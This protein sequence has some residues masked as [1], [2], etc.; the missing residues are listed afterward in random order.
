MNKQ[1]GKPFPTGNHS[2]KGR[3]AGS[4]NKTSLF[5]EQ[6]LDGDAEAI[7]RKVIEMALG[8]DHTAMRLC[9]ER[10]CPPRRERQMNVDLPDIKTADDIRVAFGTIV[11]ALPTGNITT[12]QAERVTRVLDFG[13]KAIETQELEQ[14]VT[15]LENKPT[16]VPDERR[17]A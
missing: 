17:A 3:P 6:L 1:R 2:S 13:R 7:T 8:G 11:Q 10:L 12:D 15:K 9:M 16:E 5:C 4:R 14:R